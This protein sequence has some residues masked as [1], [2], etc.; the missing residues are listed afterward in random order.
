MI[1]YGLTKDAVLSII[2][3]VAIDTLG[4]FP[5]FRKSYLRPF[6]EPALTYFFGFLSFLLSVGAL[7][8]YSLITLFYPLTLV[9]MN[10]IFVLFL[11]VRRKILGARAR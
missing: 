8:A 9:A 11:L 7:Q 6:D 3:A 4:F 2:L 10:S 1:I 5:T